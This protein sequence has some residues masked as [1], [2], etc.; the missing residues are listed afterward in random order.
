VRGDES[1]LAR[2]TELA[3]SFGTPLYAYDAD[4]VRDAFRA[5][6]ASFDLEGTRFHYAIVCNK[7]ASLVRALAE[8]GAGVHANTP[9]D[10][11]A[12]LAA[13]V[14]A[15]RIVYSG[16]NLD[17]ADMDALLSWRIALNLD[18]LDQLRLR[19]ARG[20]GDV[21]LRLLVDDAPSRIGVGVDELADALAI[22]RRAGLRITTL[23][24]YA[25][26]NTLSAARFLACFERLVAAARV[27]PDLEAV[28][29]GGGFGVA[30]R[31]GE[32]ELEIARLGRELCDRVRRLAAEVGRPVALVV[33]PGRIL[34][35]RAGVLLTRVVSVK[36]RRGRRFV[37]VDTTVG[38]IAVESVYHPWHRVD[39]VAPRGASLAVPTD[40]CG[41]TTHTRDYLARSC[42][43]PELVPGDHLALSD[44][45]AY[46]Y[47]MSSHFLNRPRPAE[48]VLDGGAARLTTRRETLEDLLA[49]RVS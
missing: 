49:T 28:D 10:A 7:N 41:N 47:A 13:G 45:G 17:A 3:A 21:G 19:A 34:V 15:E 38:N 37:G 40:V 5:F 4:A 43:L 48:V 36:E 8:L 30:Y 44:V 25:G 24:M 2:A 18:S 39:A 9:G 11:H 22:A 14:P 46:G 42:R 27:L 23:H 26:T 6:R 32:P 1:L 33:E 20:P 16:T 35:A 29:V 31:D 12:A